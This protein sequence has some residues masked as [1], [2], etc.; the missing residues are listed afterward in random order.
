MNQ[1]DRRAIADIE[2]RD[3]LIMDENGLDRDAFQ[4]FKIGWNVHVWGT[5]D[6]QVRY[7]AETEQRKLPVPAWEENRAGDG[8]TP[9]E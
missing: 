7:E 4:R 1:D 8:I 9:A 3:P 5:G 2:I 6:H